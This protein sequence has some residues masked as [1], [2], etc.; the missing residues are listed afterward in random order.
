[1]CGFELYP[2]HLPGAEFLSIII[3]AVELSLGGS[4][5]YTSTDK[6]NKNELLP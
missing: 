2:P 4:S 1:M 5:S 3:T 6:T